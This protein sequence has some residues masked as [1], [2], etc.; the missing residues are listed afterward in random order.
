MR[1]T[2]ATN[3]RSRGLSTTYSSCPV[4]TVAVTGTSSFAHHHRRRDDTAYTQARLRGD[5]V[6]ALAST[7]AP[8]HGSRLVGALE[9]GTIYTSDESRPSMGTRERGGSMAA[10]GVIGAVGGDS[11]VGSGVIRALCP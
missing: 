4:S 5:G 9:S 2:S 6:D 8:L 11:T 10:I 7:H 1:L 3:V